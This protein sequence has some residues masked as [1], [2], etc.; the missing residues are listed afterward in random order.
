MEK[1]EAGVCE[2]GIGW[3]ERIGKQT[4][5]RELRFIDHRN[6]YAGF[7]FGECGGEFD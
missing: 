1:C 5:E 3:G 7:N 2:S 4:T 6:E